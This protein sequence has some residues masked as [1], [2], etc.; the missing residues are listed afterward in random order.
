MSIAKLVGAPRWVERIAEH[1]QTGKFEPGIVSCNVCGRPTT[2]RFAADE[3]TVARALHFTTRQLDDRPEAGDEP[4]HS[5]RR[6]ASFL[7]VQEVECQ[8][9]KSA[10][11]QPA[12]ESNHERMALWRTGTVCENQR[13]GRLGCGPRSINECRGSL[14]ADIDRFD[15]R[16]RCHSLTPCNRVP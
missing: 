5:I 6:F 12:R 3:E 7:H 9:I 15:E 14:V 1:H 2:H 13:C 11:A 4:W 16:V 8:D 10:F